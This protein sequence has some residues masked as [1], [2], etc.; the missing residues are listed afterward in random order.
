MSLIYVYIFAIILY[1]SVADNGFVLLSFNFANAGTQN[2]YSVNVQ[3]NLISTDYDI[4]GIVN[5]FFSY[6]QKTFGKTSKIL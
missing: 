6:Q 5:W 3:R 4:D 2:C 1:L